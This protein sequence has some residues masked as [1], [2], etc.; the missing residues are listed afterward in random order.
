MPT[1]KKAHQHD[2]QSDPAPVQEAAP[3]PKAWQSPA[4][5]VIPK[6]VVE[7]LLICQSQSNSTGVAAVCQEI[8]QF[9]QDQAPD[10]FPR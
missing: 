1:K 2:R 5:I 7:A 4:G 6:N 9:A 8:R 10:K 3:E